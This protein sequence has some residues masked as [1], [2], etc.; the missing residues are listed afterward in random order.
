MD[1]QQ[2]ISIVGN[3]KGPLLGMHKLCRTAPDNGI[4]DVASQK[5][6]HLRRWSTMQP[7]NSTIGEDITLDRRP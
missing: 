3:R 2:R 6:T 1:Q 5:R 7:D 4:L